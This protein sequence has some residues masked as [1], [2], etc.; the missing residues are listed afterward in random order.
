MEEFKLPEINNGIKITQEEWDKF[1]KDLKITNFK[2]QE[3]ND[4]LEGGLT[5]RNLASFRNTYVFNESD[6]LDAD[7]PF[8]MDFAIIPETI[9]IVKV[10]V[11]F[12]IKKFR[13]Y[14]KAGVA[15]GA[16][17]STATGTP[18]GG[19]ST[20]G[21]SGS[22]SGGGATSGS[23][24]TPSG[25]GSTS[26]AGGATTPTSAASGDVTPVLDVQWITGYAN[27]TNVGDE[28]VTGKLLQ[29]AAGPISVARSTHTHTVS[30]PNHY[31]STPNHTHPSHTHTTPNHT[32]PN[33]THSTPN[34]THPNHTHDISDHTHA[35][36]YGIFEEDTSPTIHFYISED[37]VGLWKGKHGGY[38]EDQSNIDITSYLTAGIGEKMLRFTSDVRCRISARIL[39][40]LDIKAR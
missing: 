29:G 13:A 39:L 38:T 32:H 23:K 24:T 5:S 4:N 15:D 1:Q 34:H 14:S 12:K 28:N 20:S 10:E 35:A 22:A 16:Q 21:A 6:S 31:H 2:L 3:I 33:H 30:I 40:K 19:G 25:G 7:Y 9:K 26:G 17:T 11:S 8:E 27:V 18:S 37:P 36:Q